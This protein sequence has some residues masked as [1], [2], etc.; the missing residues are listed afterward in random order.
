[1]TGLLGPMGPI[2]SADIHN[3]KAAPP[4][5]GERYGRW[6]GPQVQFMTLPG[7]GTI[8]FDTSQLTLADLR[9]MRGH[10]QI[11]SSL[12]VLTFMMHQMGWHIECETEEDC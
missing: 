10:Y 1:V 6:A 8:A 5:L 9:Q 12:S 11:N 2:S 3:K 4:V 7:G